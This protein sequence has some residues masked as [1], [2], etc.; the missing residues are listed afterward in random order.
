MGLRLRY[1]IMKTN[2]HSAAIVREDAKRI[3]NIALKRFCTE[4][5]KCPPQLYKIT[6]SMAQ[7]AWQESK[8]EQADD[9]FMRTLSLNPE[10]AVG[11]YIYLCYL[12]ERDRMEEAKIE[13]ERVLVSAHPYMDRDILEDI[14]KNIR[15]LL[16]K[17]NTDGQ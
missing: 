4:G 1:A 14:E 16:N 15:P 12:V 7:I 10:Y 2:L 9:F 11:R 6:T 13:M 5:L 3:G 17:S 8:F